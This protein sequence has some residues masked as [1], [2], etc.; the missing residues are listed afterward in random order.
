MSTNLNI[1]V[2]LE[3]DTIKT[4]L[5][6]AVNDTVEQVDTLYVD[7]STYEIG[8]IVSTEIVAERDGS[9]EVRV[10]VQYEKTDGVFVSKD[11]LLDEFFNFVSTDITLDVEVNV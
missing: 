4:A 1:V 7:D 8:N 9:Y 11:D 2:R 5:E 6:Q 10:V 3:A